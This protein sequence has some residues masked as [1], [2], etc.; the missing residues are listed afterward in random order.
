M[1]L[2]THVKDYI[3][4]LHGSLHVI[5]LSRQLGDLTEKLLKRVH[6]SKGHTVERNTFQD[7]LSAA[8]SKWHQYAKQLERTGTQPRTNPDGDVY[9]SYSTEE[10]NLTG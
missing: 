10:D 7:W 2:S 3:L 4:E 1:S 8:N 9:H 5:L 6:C